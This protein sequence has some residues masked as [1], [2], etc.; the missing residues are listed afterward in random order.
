M[1]A[2]SVFKD[3]ERGLAQD[4]FFFVLQPK[5]NLQNNRLCGFECLIRWQHPRGDVLE[6]MHFV[7]VMEDS[8]LAG[9]FTDRL[10]VRASQTLAQWRAA[11]HNTLGLSINLSAVELGQKDL[12]GKI[13]AML[14][15]LR[16]C[17]ANFEIELTDVVHPGQLDWLVDAIQAVRSTGA[18]VALDGCGA[19]FN[20][21]TLLQQLPVDIVKFDRSLMEHVLVND[22]S[23]RMIESLVRLAQNHGKRVVLTGLETVEQYR[24][25][26]TLPDIDGQG[27]FIGEPSLEANVE[28]FSL[29]V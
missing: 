14:T 8:H 19:G 17:P 27:F 18:R 9:R 3:V 7:S 6:P 25:A 2:C 24:W 11:G 28:T 4:E 13:E 5:V 16:V 15:S 21:F 29:R 1:P 12:P 10:L 22:E 26:Q 23:R 20:S